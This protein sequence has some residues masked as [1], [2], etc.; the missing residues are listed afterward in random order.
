MA[1]KKANS[2]KRVK[3]S[4]GGPWDGDVWSPQEPTPRAIESAEEYGNTLRRDSEI[5]GRLFKGTAFGDKDIFYV[6]DADE[7]RVMMPEHGGLARDLE[8]FLEK[9]GEDQAI[10]I[11]YKG[12]K[13][14][15]SGKHKGKPCHTYDVFKTEG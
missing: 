5:E 14:L 12:T 6:V 1:T 8:L 9:Y 2:T 3:V 13:P 15:K 11:E 7:V 4:A 10:A